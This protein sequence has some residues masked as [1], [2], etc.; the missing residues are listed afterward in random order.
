MEKYPRVGVAAIIRNEMG[1]LLLGL[2]KSKH[3]NGTWGFP[4]G[5]LEFMET[6]EDCL[7]REVMEETSL[8]VT[9]IKKVD[10]TNDFYP[11]EDKHYITLF[12]EV[13]V[14]GEPKVREPDKCAE[15]KW[16]PRNQLPKNLMP[17]IVHLIEQGYKF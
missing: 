6:P 3:A 13:W 11:D 9:E 14:E 4:G 17:P 8:R 5:H 10:Y 16:F 2:R 12:Y 1:E 7:A 15:W